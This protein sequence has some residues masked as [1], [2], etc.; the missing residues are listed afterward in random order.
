MILTNLKS[1]GLIRTGLLTF[2]LISFISALLQAEM[3]TFQKLRENVSS[4]W[5]EH[6]LEINDPSGEQLLK[7]GWAYYNLGRYDKAKILMEKSLEYDNNISALYCLGMIDLKYHR[8]EEGLDKLK[9]V[10]SRSPEHLP[11]LM[12]LGRTYFHQHYYKKSKDFFEKAVSV[13]P[14][15][16]GA[17]LWLGRTY[18]QLDDP[19]KALEV[20]GTVTS[21]KEAA[22][23]A[24]LIKKL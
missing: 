23:A 5:I 17:R 13:E 20:L 14:T 22:E 6:C 15:N 24:L 10:N 3:P 21:G 18:V 19:E 7:N 1:L 11:T 2:I 8:Y 12:E 9:Q 16:S 4:S